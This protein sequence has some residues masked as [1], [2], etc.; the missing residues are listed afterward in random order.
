[1]ITTGMDVTT[2]SA[3]VY[4]SCRMWR[5]AARASNRCLPVRGNPI[6]PAPFGWVPLI[7]MRRSGARRCGSGQ[8]S[9]T[10]VDH[11]REASERRE[12]ILALLAD[13]CIE[14]HRVLFLPPVA[15]RDVA[16]FMALY[17]I[18]GFALDTIPFSSGTTSFDSLW[19][20]V[21]L[22]ALEG[23][24]ICGRMAASI[25]RNHGHPEWAA[26]SE[27]QYVSIVCTLARNVEGRKKLRNTLRA[28][29]LTSPLCD[30]RGLA[31]ALEDAF[32]AM[33]DRW[34]LSV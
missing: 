32:Q 1:M 3:K 31:R 27:D 6:E 12:R 18:L 34:Q 25:A 22:V 21:P 23:I 33:Y 29:M 17:D 7:A 10:L 11:A 14:S 19:M 24:R 9:C 4:G 26:T 15:G 20:G 16:R 30:G 5:I 28:S 13:C 8:R 2:I